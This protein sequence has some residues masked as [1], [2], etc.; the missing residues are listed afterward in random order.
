MMAD[1]SQLVIQEKLP[2]VASLNDVFSGKATFNE[3]V[4]P[5]KIQGVDIMG[6][7]EVASGADQITPLSGGAR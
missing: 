4:R 1:E 6:A 7:K 3:A 2:E 5:S